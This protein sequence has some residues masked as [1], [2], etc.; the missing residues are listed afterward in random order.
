MK[1][2]TAFGVCATFLFSCTPVYAV[3][4]A[5]VSDG[6]AVYE[7]PDFDS[8]VIDFLNYGANV[9]VSK[10]SFS[11]VGGMGLF[12]KVRVKTGKI[13]F[14]PDTDI[15]VTDKVREAERERT[16]NKSKNKERDEDPL[17]LHPKSKAFSD[18]EEEAR[19]SGGA[20]IYLT[21]YLGGA[22]SMVNVTEKFEGR[23]LADQLMFFGMRMIGPGT[24][25]DGPPLDLNIGFSM[26]KPS[27]YNRF[28]GG[29]SGFMLMGDVMAMFP[30]VNLDDW[31]VTYGL[32]VMWNFSK[33]RV[34]VKRQGT[35]N[36]ENTDTLEL[37]IGADVGVG[38]SRRFMKKFM[39][40][41]DAKYYYEK[42]QYMGYMLSFHREY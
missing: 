26:D 39:L 11:G 42:T 38:V 30:L 33:Y 29:A 1:L 3:P 21:R 18:D 37:R 40:R 10:K 32:G 34:Q 19:G 13:G 15:R 27:Y 28:S 14:I 25:F 35:N 5:V 22:V 12:H 41:A 24:L 2:F 6:A 8:K 17:Q 20:P 36:P 9:Q 16:S 4:A 7:K 31:A 23:K